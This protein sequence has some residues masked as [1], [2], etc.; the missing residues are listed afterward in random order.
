MNIFG[1]SSS[2][3]S[4]IIT[5]AGHLKKFILLHVILVMTEI[6]ITF[7]FRGLF[8]ISEIIDFL[9]WSE[10]SIQCVIQKTLK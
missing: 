4:T 8:M 9:I 7:D 2:L 1:V 5:I 10:M 3:Q 6:T